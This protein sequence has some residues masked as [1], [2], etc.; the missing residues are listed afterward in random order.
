MKI[1]A[2]SIKKGHFIELN[3]EIFQVLKTEH[4][5][6]GRGSAT[7]RFKMRNVKSGNALETSFKTSDS[8]V[9]IDVDVVKLSYLYKDADS[10][11]FMDETTYEQFTINK[12]IVGSVA[13]YLKESD[14]V[15]AL[16]YKG[17]TIAIRPPQSVQL[18]VTEAEDAIKGDTA[19]STK[20]TVTLETGITANVP[21]FIKTGDIISLDPETGVYV[22]RVSK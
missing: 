19:T 17:E 7:I 16:M 22:E 1:D 6:R 10:L 15:Y 14:G 20:K 12:K 8:V 11:Y 18:K 3:N 9:S 2:G 21:L 4:N 5:F 13:G